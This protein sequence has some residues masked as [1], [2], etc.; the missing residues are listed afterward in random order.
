MPQLQTYKKICKTPCVV[1]SIAAWPTQISYS[2][3]NELTYATNIFYCFWKFVSLCAC[4]QVKK[5]RDIVGKVICLQHLFCHV[6]WL[7][8]QVPPTNMLYSF[9]SRNILK[10]ILDTNV[11]FWIN[12]ILKASSCNFHHWTVLNSD[13]LWCDCKV[14]RILKVRT[15]QKWAL[16]IIIQK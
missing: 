14:S 10:S 13:I 8:S 15:D 4:A 6:L 12:V 11:N 3:K 2:L 1:N 9:Y 7:A 5:V 16:K